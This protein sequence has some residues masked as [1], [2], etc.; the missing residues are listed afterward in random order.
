[1]TALAQQVADVSMELARMQYHY[2]E[3]WSYVIYTV[4]GVT[5]VIIYYAIIESRPDDSAEENLRQFNLLKSLVGSEAAHRR[6]A[7]MELEANIAAV[8]SI[9]IGYKALNEKI[10]QDLN[11]YKKKTDRNVRI[12]DKRTK[13]KDKLSK[14]QLGKIKEVAKQV[15]DF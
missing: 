4:I 7:I 3:V 15:R 2:A 10:I 1:M 12:L 11:D 13:R 14:E 5:A 6:K 8:R 9:A